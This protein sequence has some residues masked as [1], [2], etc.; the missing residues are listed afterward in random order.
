M[1]AAW[2][3]PDILSVSLKNMWVSLLNNTVKRSERKK[4][5]IFRHYIKSY[6]IYSLYYLLYFIYY[7]KDFLCLLTSFRCV[8]TIAVV[9]L[10]DFVDVKL[11]RAAAL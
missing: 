1:P 11:A 9:A 2:Y 5:A 3:I 7:H 6:G 10:N 8:E 4:I